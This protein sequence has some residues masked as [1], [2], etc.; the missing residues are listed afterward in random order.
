MEIIQPLGEN[1]NEILTRRMAEKK[2]RSAW[3]QIIYVEL[4]STFSEFMLFEGN[5]N[6]CLGKACFLSVH[7]TLPRT[8]SSNVAEAAGL[9]AVFLLSFL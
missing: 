6:S 1:E 8:D 3:L 4:S 5:K 2:A 7:G 9:L